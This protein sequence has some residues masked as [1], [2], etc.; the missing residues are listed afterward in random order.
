MSWIDGATFQAELDPP[1]RGAKRV[2]YRICAVDLLGYYFPEHASTSPVHSVIGD[3]ATPWLDVT[4]RTFAPFE[5]SD[6]ATNITVTVA[7]LAGPDLVWTARVAAAAAPFSVSNTAWAHSGNNDAWRVTTNR[8][9]NGDAVWYCGDPATRTYPNGCHAALDTPSFTVGTGGG[10][11]FRQWIRTEYDTGTHYWDGA[12]ICL[13]T[14]GGATFALIEPTSGYPCQITAN[15][16]SPFAP[17]QPCLAGDG[18]TWETLLLD[19]SAYAGQSVIVRFEFGSDLYIIDE[20]W[21]IAGVTPFSLDA[22]V[23]PWLAPTGAWGG[24]LPDG[25]STPIGA[26]LDPA[27]IAYNEECSACIRIESNDPTLSPLLIPLTLRR[28]HQL[29]LNAYGPGAFT[30]DRTFLFRDAKATVTFRADAGC[31][32]Y[33][34][35]LNGVPYPGVYD[36]STSTKTM[37][38]SAL[39]E[40]QY[41]SAWFTPKTWTLTV[42]SSVTNVY[43]ETG[44]YTLTNGTWVDAMAISPVPLA[45]NPAVRLQSTDWTLAGHTPSAG[46]APSVRFAITNHATLSWQWSLAFRLTANAGANGTVTP[47]QSWYMAG[48]SAVVTASPA[49]YHHLASWSGDLLNAIQEESRLS[50][51]MSSPRTVA[52]LFAPNLTP[53][54]GVPEYWLAQ[55]GWLQDFEQAAE[56]D[57]DADGMP[58]WAEWRADT[59]PTNAQSRLA[60]TALRPVSN[61]WSLVWIGGQARTQN[62]QRADSPAGPWTTLSPHFPPTPVTNSVELPTTLPTGF[63]R[64]AVP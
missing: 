38:F 17:D 12:V 33:S 35:I 47:P 15:T 19:L 59:D 51:I 28:G 34:L 48:S 56:N 29:I 7:N 46:T 41:L 63:F 58:T 57:A 2:D 37:T 18:E 44:T 20:G 24:A 23:P 36:Y 53:S 31:Y 4:P 50:V 26:T 60:L 8:T 54:R 11:L 42:A 9:W 3:Y 14:N 39:S 55:Y 10:L 62:V 16:A 45:E 6:A 61:G 52:A 49:V 21:Y 5:R 25:W 27:A 13:S 43:P 64:I 32:L 30:S 22:P 40:D 1:S